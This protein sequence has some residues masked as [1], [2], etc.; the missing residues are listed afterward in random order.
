MCNE[1]GC[2]LTWLRISRRLSAITSINSGPGSIYS[3]SQRYQNKI[4]KAPRFLRDIPVYGTYW[5]VRQCNMFVLGSLPMDKQEY[6]NDEWQKHWW[7]LGRTVSRLITDLPWYLVSTKIAN[8]L[9]FSIIEIEIEDRVWRSRSSIFRRSPKRSRST[10]ICRPLQTIDRH[11]CQ[12][13]SLTLILYVRRGLNALPKE[14]VTPGV[15][16]ANASLSLEHVNSLY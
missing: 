1:K 11:R 4:R 6:K 5:D 9:H 2:E 16:V 3:C 7:C 14:G 13:R 8:W 12:R 15:P 10:F